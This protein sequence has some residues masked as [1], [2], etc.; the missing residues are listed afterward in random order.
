M[1]FVSLTFPQLQK[2]TS[3]FELKGLPYEVVRVNQDKSVL[4]LRVYVEKH[5]HIGRAFFK[6]LID[7]N[8]DKLTPDEYAMFSPG[9]AK[10][11]RNI[12][13]R[14]STSFNLVVQTSGSRYKIEA[15]TCN[16]KNNSLLKQCKKLSDR[17]N[18]FNLYPL[19]ANSEATS[20]MHSTLKKL[21]TDDEPIVDMLY[22]SINRSIQS[23]E[24]G[25][26]AKLASELNSDLLQKMFI[27]KA[28]KRG[29]FFCF[30][31]KLSRS[32]EPDIQYLSPELNYV[33]SY[34]IH[35]G[36]QLEQDIWSV[37]GLVQV[38]DITNETLSRYNIM[39]ALEAS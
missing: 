8:K 26:I 16:D 1:T 15:I 24:Q 25:V 3:A 7:K 4:N 32:N 21:S 18:H 17:V 12:Y 27:R 29:E 37:A 13:S 39:K 5:Q 20:L 10:A 6:A 19:L 23:I 11:L 22:V 28:L 38:F 30:Q 31:V 35:R 33:S 9:L 36:K 2:I 14:S 34:A